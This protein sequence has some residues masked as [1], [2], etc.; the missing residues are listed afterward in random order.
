[1]G[2]FVFKFIFYEYLRRKTF[3]GFIQFTKNVQVFKI[4]WDCPFKSL[5]FFMITS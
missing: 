3:N 4:S 2:L 1:M 5:E